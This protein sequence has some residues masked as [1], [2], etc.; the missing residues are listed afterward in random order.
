MKKFFRWLPALLLCAAMGVACS[1]DEPTKGP[2]GS[3]IDTPS[4]ISALAKSDEGADIT[5]IAV[6]QRKIEWQITP[7]P[8]C[9]S[10]RVDV[11]VK[12]R[13]R[14]DLWE[15]R[16]T[17]PELT[18]E[19]YAQL[20]MFATDGTGAGAWKGT[21]DG[22]SEPRD[23]STDMTIFQGFW[24][25][26]ME[27]II[28]VWGCLSDNGTNPS[29]YTEMTVRTESAGELIGNPEVAQT[30]QAN[31]RFTQI[32]YT[33]NEDCAGYFHLDTPKA[34]VDEILAAGFSE[35]ELS[36]IVISFGAPSTEAVD[37]TLD[38]GFNP[39]K[40]EIYSLGVAYD[41]NYTRNPKIFYH[42]YELKPKDP[43]MELP[44][45]KF[46]FVKTSSCV[47]R[48]DVEFD[49]PTTINAYYCLDPSPAGQLPTNAADLAA[50]GG[51]I[52]SKDD[53]E[54]WQFVNPDTD[55][56]I[57]ITARNKQYDLVEPMG[58]H[59]LCH[60]KPMGN[61]DEPKEKMRIEVPELGDK[62]KFRVDFYPAE[63][64]SCFFFCTLE[65][66]MTYYDPITA[67]MT[68]TDLTDPKNIATMRSYMINNANIASP[69]IGAR[70]SWGDFT[71][72]GL[73][74]GKEYVTF[75]LAETWDGNFVDV[76]YKTISTKDNP[77][78]PNPKI[79]FGEVTIK[80]DKTEWNV[81]LIPNADV[82]YM[83]YCGTSVESASNS[84]DDP[85]NATM[86]EKFTAWSEYVLGEAGMYN[87]GTEAVSGGLLRNDMLVL[88]LGYGRDENGDDVYSDLAVMC[89]YYA[90]NTYEELKL[91]ESV[92]AAIAKVVAKH[93]LKQKATPKMAK[94]LPVLEESNSCCI[95]RNK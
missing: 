40:N 18:W 44:Q 41:A 78:G 12:N 85:K 55:Y 92:K 32:F 34:H 56:K 93:D 53:P 9:K 67:Q 14:N 64:I 89:Y 76:Q 45:Y 5:I 35:A 95:I 75:V 54:Q 74:P 94:P 3:G 16:K 37:Y 63:D 30:S 38:W 46:T 86:E 43:N 84:L 1:D 26:D 10:Y 2:G 48:F 22:V 59:D 49:Y 82:Y 25:P 7:R 6:D 62:T 33:P 51:W 66:G 19:E 47:V 39:P 20:R 61:F 91:P 57:L 70:E 23:F 50:N 8:D 72:T 90:T 13:F 36:D 11:K 77:G 17:T 80:E 4:E 68:D 15:A 87:N 42:A 29:E 65:K 83:R 58:V 24:L 73:E 60:T 21:E 81:Q 31:A 69:L 71:Y 88:A 52:V 28:M 27:Y 79:E